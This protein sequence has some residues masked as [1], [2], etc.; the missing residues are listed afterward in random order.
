MAH[1]L[2]YGVMQLSSGGLFRSCKNFL[3]KYYGKEN[4]ICGKNFLYAKGTLPVMLIAHLDTVFYMPPSEIFCD[5]KKQVM[6][7]EEAGVGDDRAGVYAILEIVMGSRP[8]RTPHVLF[9]LEEEKGGLGASEAGAIVNLPSD[10][11]FLIELDRRGRNDCVF[12]QCNNQAFT[13]YI[14]SFGFEK[15][16]GTFTDISILMDDWNIC[17][18]NL[19]VGYYNEH[20]YSEILRYDELYATIKAV[21]NI[22]T[23]VYENKDKINF[24]YQRNTRYYEELYMN[25]DINGKN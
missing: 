22:L 21:N 20:T 4:V 8:D 18:V 7:S 23:D 19:S 11:K 14:E 10:V 2:L 25:E 16:I 1:E 13:N 12:Y 15:Q 6:W 5:E 24:N 17:G 9:T 3:Y